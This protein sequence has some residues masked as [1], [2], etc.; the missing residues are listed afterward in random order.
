MKFKFINYSV[1]KVTNLFMYD[2][3]KLP[4]TFAKAFL[5]QKTPTCSLKSYGNLKIIDSG[6]CKSKF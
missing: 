6:C 3:P 2:L 1:F 4:V 5:G